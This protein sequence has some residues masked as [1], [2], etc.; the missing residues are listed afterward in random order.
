MKPRFS[1][2]SA[3]M[4]K[5]EERDV[6]QPPPPPGYGQSPY[7]T[8]PPAGGP[9]SGPYGPPPVPPQAGAGPGP[10]GVPPQQPPYPPYP[11]GPQPGPGGGWG[12]PPPR[13]G[14]AGKVLAIIAASIAGLMLLSWFGN[15]SSRSAGGSSSDVS[16]SPRYKVSL[17]KTLM[18]GEYELSKDMSDDAEAQNP[19]LG[20]DDAEF[21]AM[22]EGSSAREQMLFS[23]LNSD[24]TGGDSYTESDDKV[25]DNMEEDPSMDVAVPRREVT[26]SG[27]GETLTCEVLT[28]SENGQKLSVPVCA[29]GDRGSAGM[30]AE[31][32][33]DTMLTDPQ[34]VDLDAFADTVDKVRDDV[35]SPA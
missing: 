28:K 7:G 25:L 26:P 24:S 35:R 15:M 12:P 22:Y 34:D 9:P 3:A 29:W 1:V 20:S 23:G 21:L 13:K 17:P 6:T 16:S 8:P 33:Y 18:D 32:S 4:N 14:N 2:D 19:E 11:Y 27:G 31:N 10:Y 5:K 30:V